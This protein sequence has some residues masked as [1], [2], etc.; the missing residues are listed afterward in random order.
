MTE[1][2][3][4]DAK[5]ALHEQGVQM[6]FLKSRIL[7]LAQ[8]L[9][10]RVAERDHAIAERDRLREELEEARREIVD[11]RDD[12]RTEREAQEMANGSPE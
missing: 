2:L 3:Q 11:L 8:T 12:I 9:G 10:V 1:P 4:I 7:A 5:I 6:E